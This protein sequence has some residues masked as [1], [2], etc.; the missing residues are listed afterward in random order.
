MNSVRRE[1][2]MALVILV[3][4]LQVCRYALKILS[5]SNGV[6]LIVVPGHKISIGGCRL[7]V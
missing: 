5:K 4:T 2:F 3:H 1:E 6:A 7:V